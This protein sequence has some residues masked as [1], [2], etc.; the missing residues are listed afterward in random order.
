[1]KRLWPFLVLN[2]IISAATVLI[3]LAIWSSSHP[4]V[5]SAT[6]GIASSG[7]TVTQAPTATLPPQGEPLFA[8]EAVI[9]AGDIQNEHIQIKY[10]GSEP[11]S[12]QGWQ[13]SDG[14]KHTYTFGNFVIYK[15]GAFD[16]YTRSGYAT[17]IELYMGFSQALWENAGE[18]SLID[19]SG[20]T[21]LSYSSTK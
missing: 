20:A 19:P 9:G 18:F 4:C 14:K 13:I 17:T 11:L 21:R 16:L 6:V 5:S 15:N 10:L 8:V 1:M 12:L 2:V 3:V 7:V